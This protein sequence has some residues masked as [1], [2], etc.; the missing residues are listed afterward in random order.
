MDENKRKHILFTAMKLFNEH[1]FHATP[2]SLIAKK[3]KVS[4]GTLF[5]YFTTKEELIHAIYKD[6]K[7]HSKSVFINQLRDC[8]TPH[9]NLRSMWAAVIIWGIENP[10]EFNYMELFLH[11]P[12]KKLCL[13]EKKMETF[14]KFRTSIL[15]SI[16]PKTICIEYPEYSTVFIDNALHGTINFLLENDIDDKGH[17][18]NASFELLWNG[19]SQK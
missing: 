3:A 7:Y 17:F 5:N 14:S 6:I 9:D 1:G 19:F 15:Q 4:V 10:E 13:D 11:S 12:F 2:T 18:I 8:K 16:S